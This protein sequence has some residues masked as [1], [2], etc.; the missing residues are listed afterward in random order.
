MKQQQYLFFRANYVLVHEIDDILFEIAEECHL[1]I[2]L[3]NL[4]TIIDRCIGV[5]VAN[6]D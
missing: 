5:T 1:T 6:E 3:E 2:Q 4:D